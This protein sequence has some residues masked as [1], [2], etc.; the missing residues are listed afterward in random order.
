[1]NKENIEDILKNKKIVEKIVEV[2]P[3]WGEK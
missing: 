2:I 3:K 1:M